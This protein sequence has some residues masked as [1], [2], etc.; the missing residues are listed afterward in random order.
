MYASFEFIKHLYIFPK[1]DILEITTPSFVANK[2]GRKT[3]IQYKVM[4]T[5]RIS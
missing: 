1:L 4:F 3:A 5:I 2:K